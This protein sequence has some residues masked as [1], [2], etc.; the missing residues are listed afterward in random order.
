MV[1]DAVP[2]GAVAEH[3]AALPLREDPVL[4]ALVGHAGLVV[5][6][7]GEGDVDEEGEQQKHSVSLECGESC[8]APV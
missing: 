5:E 6:G 3:L 2:V 1:E 7:G 4:L 8:K